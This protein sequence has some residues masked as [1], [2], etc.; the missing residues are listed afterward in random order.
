MLLNK[1]YASGSIPKDWKVADVTAIHKKGSKFDPGNYRPVS[2]TSIV[3]KIAESFVR[4]TILEYMEMNNFLSDCQ[5][6]F[7]HGRSCVSQLLQVMDDISLMLDNEEP[8][9]VVYFDF[10]K[11]FDTVPHTRLMTKLKSFGITGTLYTWIDDFLRERTQR[12]RVNNIYSDYKPVLSGI[13]QGSVLGPLLFVVFINDLPN[14]IENFIQIF[15]DDTKLYG[16]AA[17]HLS[18]Q[19]DVNLLSNWSDTWQLGFNADK[20]KVMHL[21]N[22]NPKVSYSIPS[23]NE[24][25]TIT[26]VEEEKDLGV[27]FDTDMKFDRHINNVVSRANRILMIIRRTFKYLDEKTFVSLYKSMVRP[28]LEYANSVW[29]P[30]LVRQS[31]LIEGVQRRATFMLRSLQSKSY[32]ERLRSLKLPSLKYRRLR[33]D[34]IEIYKIVHGL[35]NISNQSL[36]PFSQNVSTRGHNFKIASQFCKTSFR[37]NTLACRSYSH[38]NSLSHA[39][40]NAKNLNCFKMC[41]DTELNHLQFDYD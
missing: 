32:T 28:I 36:L 33:G 9:D 2:L 18:L 5:H 38:W 23:K 24:H 12:V 37:K 4:D 7:R 26:E 16:K 27:I 20:C 19:N 6:G 30:A 34:M 25:V 29:H 13:P 15:A 31:A 8:V 40:V 22:K 35:L 11:A 10:R 41:I 1:T 17:N 21:S 39:T 3:C 14:G